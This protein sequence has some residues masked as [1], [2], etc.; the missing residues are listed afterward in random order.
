MI[1]TTLKQ[2]FFSDQILVS[3][4]S[5]F[6]GIYQFTANAASQGLRVFLSWIALLSVNLGILNLL[7]IPALDGG[8]IAFIGYEAVTGKKPNQKFENVLHTIVFI[9]LIG[10]MLFVTYNDILRL[11]GF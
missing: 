9:L 4:L 5:G 3:D 11:F 8:R 2:L 10:L 1:V 7:P 6:V